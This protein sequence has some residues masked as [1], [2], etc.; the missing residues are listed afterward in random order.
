[1]FTQ[2]PIDSMNLTVN[3]TIYYT[4]RLGR[5]YRSRRIRMFF[6]FFLDRESSICHPVFLITYETGRDRYRNAIPS[7]RARA[8][9]RKRKRGTI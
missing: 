9:T 8:R 7:V 1:M 5:N 4:L 3:V 6:W 2:D